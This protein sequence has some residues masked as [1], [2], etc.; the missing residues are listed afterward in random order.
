MTV[1]FRLDGS[2]AMVTGA[3]GG[4]GRAIAD[5]LSDLG[6]TVIGT[7]R[8]PLTAQQLADR[9]GTAP[10]VLD[11]VDLGSMDRAVDRASED[12]PIDILV[13]N[14]G[15]NAPQPALQVDESTWNRILDTNLKGP[16]FLT[17]AVAR[18]L[19]AAGRP[20]AVVNVS[21]QAGSVGIEERAAYCASKGGLDQLTRVLAIELAAHGI[22]VNGVGPT[23]VET[24]LT[25]SSLARPEVREE[26]LGRIPLGMFAQPEDVVGAAAFLAGPMSSM[27]TGHTLLVDGGWTAR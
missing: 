5:G 20:G 2:R 6:A 13:N 15:V 21:S 8:D 3:A 26:F 24:A 7:S 9:Y 27:V 18:R 17:Q 12:G 22:R 25:R 4:L 23:F 19:V 16:F 11:A 1:S 14:A 10:C